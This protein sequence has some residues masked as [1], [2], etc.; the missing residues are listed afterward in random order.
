[1]HIV[2]EKKSFLS[3]MKWNPALVKKLRMISQKFLDRGVAQ[4]LMFLAVVDPLK[5]EG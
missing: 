3:E 2:S 5:W 4:V 1:M